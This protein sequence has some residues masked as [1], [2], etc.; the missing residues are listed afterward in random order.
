M[1]AIGRRCPDC[2]RDRHR[3]GPHQQ[4]ELLDRGHA[5]PLRHQSPQAAQQ[6]QQHQQP[7]ALGQIVPYERHQWQFVR[8][9]RRERVDVVERR[10]D[11]VRGAVHHSGIFIQSNMI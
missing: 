3:P 5:S 1:W 9:W 8:G 6:Q 4:V 11:A 7:P 2:E 10:R